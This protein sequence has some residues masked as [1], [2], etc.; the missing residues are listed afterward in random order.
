MRM[1]DG[2]PPPA[3][4]NVRWIGH[5]RGQQRQRG[6]AMVEMIQHAR[7]SSCR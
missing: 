4:A 2:V 1:A 7:T 6:H 3:E 5:A